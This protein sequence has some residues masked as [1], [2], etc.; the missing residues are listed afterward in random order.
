VLLLY[1]CFSTAALHDCEVTSC[2]ALIKLLF[3]LCGRK[4][5]TIVASD[6]HHDFVMFNNPN[7]ECL[8]PENTS[9]KSAEMNGCTKEQQQ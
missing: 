9:I 6:C 2:V 3:C 5:E 7:V 4:K 1:G 8:H